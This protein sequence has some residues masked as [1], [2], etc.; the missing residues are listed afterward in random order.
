MPY[1]SFDE[2]GVC[3]FCRDYETRGSYLKGE[4]ALE[5]FVSKYRSATGEIDVLLGFSGGRDSAYGLDYIKNQS[6]F[7]SYNF[8]L[9]LGNG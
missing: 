3:S 4:K 1:I 6:G 7:A 9:R 5:E 8:H 2:E